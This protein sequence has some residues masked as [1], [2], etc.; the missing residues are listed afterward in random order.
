MFGCILVVSDLSI[1]F[2]RH[3]QAIIIVGGLV[4]RTL[5]VFPELGFMLEGVIFVG[6]SMRY[7]WF[8]ASFRQ[9]RVIMVVICMMI[10]GGC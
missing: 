9:G 6:L 10:R 4:F 3:F 1:T 7:V 5:G 2:W 8:V